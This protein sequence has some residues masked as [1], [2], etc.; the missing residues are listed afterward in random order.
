MLRD[1]IQIFIILAITFAPS[2]I[3][4]IDRSQ[5]SY[6]LPQYQV[7]VGEL[8]YAPKTAG[9]TLYLNN[10]SFEDIDKEQSFAVVGL[11]SSFTLPIHQIDNQTKYHFFQP[12]R[13]W[14]S[15]RLIVTRPPLENANQLRI[16]SSVWQKVNNR[17]QAKVDREKM[18]KILS[19]EDTTNSPFHC[20]KLPLSSMRVSKFASPRYLPNG[21]SY[22]HSGLD[23]RAFTPTPLTSMG[24]G[25]VVFA[26]FMMT[27]GNMVVVSH[28]KGLFSRYMHLSKLDVKVGDQVKTGQKIGLT[29]STGRVEAPHLHWEIIWKGN[30]ANPENFLLQWERICGQ[31]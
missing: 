1:K 22:Y 10:K 14:V 12:Y 23:L 16:P 18:A 6:I 9:A 7:E 27:P 3:L 5:I 4:Q 26:D 28:G 25:T 24:S 30:H 29:G 19:I 15:Q 2:F 20:M 8:L 17:D 11:T 31:S 21:N 13:T